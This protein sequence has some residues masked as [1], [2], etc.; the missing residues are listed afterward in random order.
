MKGKCGIVTLDILSLDFFLCCP[1]GGVCVDVMNWRRYYASQF[2]VT[3]CC[4][5]RA[6]RVNLQLHATNYLDEGPLWEE[7]ILQTCIICPRE[8]IIQNIGILFS[9]IITAKK[10]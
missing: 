8:M 7:C 2:S 5:A 9:E 4:D 10:R 1:S 3:Q 6:P